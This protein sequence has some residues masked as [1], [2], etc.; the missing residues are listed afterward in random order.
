MSDAELS[1]EDYD[2]Q[3]EQL[4]DFI[5]FNPAAR[6]RRRLIAREILGLPRPARVLDAGCGLGFTI[7][8]IQTLLPEAA[9]IGLDFSPGAIAWASNRFP[10]IDW[11]CGDLTAMDL[12]E[13][14]DLVVCTEVIEHIRDYEKVIANLCKAIRPG[15]HLILTTQAGRVHQTEQ[16]VGHLRHFKR[17][18][19]LSRLQ[20]QGL[21]SVTALSWGWPALTVLKYVS[22]IRADKTIEIF[23]SGSY[24][25][26]SRT[27]NHIAYFCTRWMSFKSSPFGSQILITCQKFN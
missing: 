5:R 10:T 19:L 24:G 4:G 1:S 8:H 12:Y 9:L 15:G 3:W 13:E 17:H 21:T 7:A 18:E 11:R 14:F 23:G 16:Y 20:E 27:I 25:R 2:S 26:I 6:H 22:N